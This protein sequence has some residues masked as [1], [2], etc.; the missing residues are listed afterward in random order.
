[1]E[2]GLVVLTV[3]AMIAVGVF[4]FL[5]DK[6]KTAASRALSQKVLYRKKFEQ[7][8]HL[9]E[10]MTIEAA[11]SSER[12]LRELQTRVAVSDP[13]TGLAN[14]LYTAGRQGNRIEYVYGNKFG[15]S[16]RAR[17]V[18]LEHGERSLGIFRVV[19]WHEHDGIIVAQDWMKT[20]FEQIR[21]VVL[22]VDPAA[23]F[24]EGI[25][26]ARLKTAAASDAAAEPEDT[27]A[28]T[29]S[30]PAMSAEP[31]NAVAP[32]E[33]P[34][35]AT[36]PAIQA[37]APIAAPTKQKNTWSYVGMALMAAAVLWI[38]TVGVPDGL[39]P[40]WILI[41]GSGGAMF[42]FSTRAP[43]AGAAPTGPVQPSASQ[44]LQ[45]PDESASALD[46]P[47]PVEEPS[48][49]DFELAAEELSPAAGRADTA[50]AAHATPSS[51]L[52]PRIV[53][54]VAA[55][56][57][58]VIVGGALVNGISKAI[59]RADRQRA[60]AERQEAAAVE[61]DAEQ[62]GSTDS[63]DYGGRTLEDLLGHAGEDGEPVYLEVNYPG[64]GEW[65]GGDVL[66]NFAIVGEAGEYMVSLPNST[67]CFIDSKRVSFSE[68]YKATYESADR[69]GMIVCDIDG[70][71]ELHVFTQ[72][73]A[74]SASA[75]G[76]GSSLGEDIAAAEGDTAS[77]VYFVQDAGGSLLI[78]AEPDGERV[79]S[80]P[81]IMM[82]RSAE[83]FF[84]WAIPLADSYEYTIG[85]RPVSGYELFEYV[86]EQGLVRVDVVC[87]GGRIVSISCRED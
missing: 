67:P 41:G 30:E 36:M 11:A 2:S 73:Q 61:P 63:A 83:P 77:F 65:Y 23:R 22:A 20:L 54:A 43:R 16:F 70:V 56:V 68:Y 42:Y 75:A 64:G 85:D 10:G 81:S 60:A 33:A 58:V 32:A 28:A 13:P 55:L 24:T 31:G 40:V 50:A 86:C 8:K 21:A 59:A 82:V 5:M 9:L 78:N 84:E 66:L 3:V 74:A 6:A 45:S 37:P 38:G 25:D 52:V 44:P 19:R 1:M 12:L 34:A 46:V 80:R 72:G 76:S 48:P 71:R 4:I 17:V 18:I 15:D 47:A 29:L 7:G 14:Q 69:R 87:D 62:E 35:V 51:K 49:E 57:I 53:M 79:Y 27:P 39:M 26:D